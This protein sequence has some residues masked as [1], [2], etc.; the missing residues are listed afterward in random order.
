MPQ[1]Y[2]IEEYRKKA[3]MPNPIAQSGRGRQFDAIEFLY[4]VKQVIELLNLNKEHALL[5]VGCGNGLLDIILSSCCRRVTAIEPV[6]ELVALARQNLQGCPNA[7]VTVGH[8]ADIPA[9]DDS[10]HRSLVFGVLQLIP[11]QEAEMTFQ[12]LYRV[13]CS[14]GSI[15]FGSIPDVGHRDEFLTPYLSEVRSARHIPEGQKDEIVNRNLSAFWHDPAELMDWWTSRGCSAT[16]HPLV[17]QDPNHDHR[18]HLVV[19]VEK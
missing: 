2:W 12:E 4:V 14:G 13:T 11:L 7:S 5:D 17:S 3:S 16:L 15:L 1:S 10:F 6:E 8:G 19:G 9:P 18:F